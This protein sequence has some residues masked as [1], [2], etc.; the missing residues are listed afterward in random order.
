MWYV[1]IVATEF[2]D[3]FTQLQLILNHPVGENVQKYHFWGVSDAK[4]ALFACFLKLGGSIW[5]ITVLDVPGILLRR[6]GHPTSLYLERKEFPKKLGRGNLGLG[7]NSPFRAPWGPEGAQ[8]QVE[9]CVHH[10]SNSG[11]P[12]G[13][14]WDQI[15]TTGALQGPWGPPKGPFGAKTSPFRAPWGSEGARYQVKVCVDHESNSVGPMG[16]SWDQ[17]WLLWGAQK[18]FFQLGSVPGP[19]GPVWAPGGYPKGP[20]GG[21]NDLW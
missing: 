20:I 4:N 2:S 1:Q 12:M 15:W 7:P 8:Y 9:V 11:G 14:S 3:D 17:I 19:N 16:G 21:Q 6:S 10:E 18:L 13:G 5:A